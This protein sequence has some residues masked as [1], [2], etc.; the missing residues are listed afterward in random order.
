[1]E[2]NSLSLDTF[3]IPNHANH[4]YNDTYNTELLHLGSSTS[5]GMYDV[6]DIRY[7]NDGNNFSITPF[8]I[9]NET[10]SVIH[11]FLPA[12]STGFIGD[13][14]NLITSLNFNDLTSITV[15]GNVFFDVTEENSDVNLIDKT[16]FQIGVEDVFVKV[17]GKRVQNED[18]EVKTNADGYFTMSIPIG[19]QCISFEKNGHTFY[20]GDLEGD[21]DNRYCQEFSFN[22]EQNLPNFSCNTYKELR[23]RITGGQTYNNQSIEDIAIGFNLPANICWF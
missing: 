5:S 2:L 15:Q 9:L 8:T 17:G 14:T 10:Y 18:G 21:D 12:Q 22:S 7:I 13:Q 23:G 6:T 4:F 1:M 16:E 19:E 3:S 20:Y 11:E